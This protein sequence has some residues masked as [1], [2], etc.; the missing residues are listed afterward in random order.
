MGKIVLKISTCNFFV[1]LKPSYISSNN[2]LAA[3][4]HEPSPETNAMDRK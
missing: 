2:I 3:S 1:F 4:I